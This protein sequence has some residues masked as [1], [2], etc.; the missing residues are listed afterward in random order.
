MK[1]YFIYVLLC[2]DNTLYCGFTDDVKR[3]V[4][5]HSAGKGAKYTKARLPIK[6]LTFV[7]FDNKSDAM[8]CEWWFKKKLK[9]AQKLSFIE[10][11][12]IKEKFEDYQKT[13]QY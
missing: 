3:R 7:K 13:R 1:K 5:T 10:Q 8:K 9:R 12:N 4:E 11:K 2:S 6:L